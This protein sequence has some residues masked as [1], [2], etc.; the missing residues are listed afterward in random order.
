MPAP[1]E[2]GRISCR[3]GM[4]EVA[5]N[6]EAEHPRDSDGD[7]RIAGEVAVDLNAEAE[8]PEPD[9][10][11]GPLGRVGE[12]RVGMVSDITDTISKGLKTN[13]RSISVETT[14]GVF[15]GSIVLDVPDLSHLR[16]LIEKI[17]RIDGILGVHR[18]DA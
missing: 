16:K 6:V 13:I 7:V 8:R 10:C 2:I 4:I 12:D 3:V 11:A 17:R 1:P 18:L 9:D 14:D 5:G 15:E